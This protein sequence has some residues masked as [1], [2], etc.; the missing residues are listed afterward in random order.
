LNATS[1]DKSGSRATFTELPSETCTAD[2]KPLHD[3]GTTVIVCTI[4]HQLLPRGQVSTF[5]RS[6]VVKFHD[7]PQQLQNVGE[8][9]HTYT[10]T[11][12]TTRSS[13]RDN[14]AA[15]EYLP[16]EDS[17]ACPHV[18][19]A[20]TMST[21]IETQSLPESSSYHSS[22]SF[23]AS[24]QPAAVEC[25][26]SSATS[27]EQSVGFPS[28]I[29]A[30]DSKSPFHLRKR[31]FDQAANTPATDTVLA[32]Q[33]KQ[34]VEEVQ[35]NIFNT[36]TT[37]DLLDDDGR[38]G[39]MKAVAATIL[40]YGA[41][42]ISTEQEAPQL[43]QQG[44]S[45]EDTSAALIPTDADSNGKIE[46]NSKTQHRYCETEPNA[47]DSDS[48]SDSDDDSENDEDKP[49]WASAFRSRQMTDT[50]DAMRQMQRPDSGKVHQPSIAHP[51]STVSSNG[52]KLLS[53]ELSICN[54]DFRTNSTLG[55]HS[56]PPAWKDNFQGASSGVYQ[57][58]NLDLYPAQ[59]GLATTTPHFTIQTTPFTN[60]RF[61]TWKP[62]H[63]CIGCGYE[64]RFRSPPSKFDP[65]EYQTDEGSRSFIACRHNSS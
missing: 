11:E 59:I 53:A 52:S 41:F 40:D 9:C 60:Y 63:V 34:R 32:D 48:T 64:K 14:N 26:Q 17:M 55:Q 44:Y 50:Q 4:L 35:P 36:I 22:C 54:T 28:Q 39:G 30:I 24:S 3:K 13:R 21:A 27:L 10:I 19:V 65:M 29:S 62:E 49:H 47:E 45:Q 46:A 43:I 31:K 23:Q 6:T 1:H 42:P 57:E 20:N 37:P 38:I 5:S 51:I 15:A 2:V 7:K 56:V 18:L 16:K 8:R 25:G 58:P 33:K 61:Y 12:L